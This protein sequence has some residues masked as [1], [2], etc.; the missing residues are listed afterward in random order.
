MIPCPVTLESI[1]FSSPIVI[2]SRID[3]RWHNY[4]SLLKGIGLGVSPFVPPHALER[5][6]LLPGLRRHACFSSPTPSAVLWP[7]HAVKDDTGAS[8]PVTPPDV[9]RADQHVSF[10]LLPHLV[11]PFH[12]Q[13]KTPFLL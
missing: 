7:V 8:C 13:D 12:L 2:L 4:F 1:L 5:L 9:L 10:S 11:V 6:A 3:M